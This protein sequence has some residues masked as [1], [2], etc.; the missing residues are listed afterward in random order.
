[1]IREGSIRWNA[2]AEIIS[3]I[4][5]TKRKREKKRETQNDA[6][7]VKKERRRGS[8]KK[9]SQGERGRGK[10]MEETSGEEAVESS[11]KRADIFAP[12]ST[13]RMDGR[14]GKKRRRRRCEKLRRRLQ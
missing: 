3:T 7:A 8:E 11:G 6:R 12:R 2:A 9:F 4:R 13:G 5:P 1:M 14:S 10:K